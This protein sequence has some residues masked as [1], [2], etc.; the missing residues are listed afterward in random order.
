MSEALV[1]PRG[2]WGLFLD[3]WVEHLTRGLSWLTAR[4]G[5]RPARA[6]V[7]EGRYWPAGAEASASRPLSTAPSAGKVVLVLGEANGFRRRVSLPITVHRATRAVL[8][9]DL[10]RLTPLRASDLY[11]DTAVL[12]RDWASGTCWVELVAAPQTRVRQ[13]IESLEARGLEVERVVLSDRDLATGIDLLPREARESERRGHFV[14]FALLALCLVLA[15]ALALFPVWQA[16]ERV[17]ALKAE[18]GKARLEAE[19][20]SILQR[21]L[22]KQ[23]SEYN[24]LLQRKHTNPLI[25][26]LLDDLSRRL[27]DD[28]WVQTFEVKTNAQSKTRELVIQGE[29]GSGARLLQ[30]VQESPLLREPALK[31]AMTRIAPNAERFHIG[32]EVVAATL[33]EKLKPTDATSAVTVP[34]AP[35]P[36]AG[37]PSA[38]AAEARPAEVRPTNGKGAEVKGGDG[39]GAESKGAEAK[40]GAPTS[41]A[42]QPGGKP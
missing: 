10:D 22:E 3:W 18:E 32:A 24:F 35:A 6:S 36:A 1:R 41:G 26:Q 8:F 9:H 25:V 38:K 14:T 40:G 7:V 16:R 20:A 37:A 17:I 11:A 31:T 4:Q 13:Q 30:I 33:P 23:V 2:P 21:Q 42:A 27:P 39:K 29:T 15:A 34:L 28:T 12:E 19:Q 5:R